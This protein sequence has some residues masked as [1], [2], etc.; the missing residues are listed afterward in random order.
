[1]ND[2]SKAFSGWGA[3][4]V[5]L[6]ALAVALCALNVIVGNLRLRHDFTEEKLYTLSGGTRAILKGLDRDI[7]LKFYFSRSLREV[8][9]GIK[10]YA[11]Q[12]E[13]LLREYELGWMMLAEHGRNGYASEAAEA[14]AEYICEKLALEY[15]IVVMDVDNP[16]SYGCAQKA[17]F[18]LFEKRTV[19]DYSI[20]RYADDYYYFRR[21]FSKCTRENKFY[22]DV[23]YYGRSV[24]GA[25]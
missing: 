11:T 3:G 23:P 10:S 7:V 6:A 15:L 25:E 18:R 14:F 1:M 13:D 19:Y 17:G 9:M 5:A 8:P 12:V 16:A 22:G 4:A 20:G 21:Y 2:K 24:N